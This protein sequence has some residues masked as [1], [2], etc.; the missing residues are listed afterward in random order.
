M[1][2]KYAIKQD[3]GNPDNWGIVWE[4][5]GTQGGFASE[6]AAR[7]NADK[8]GGEPA[9]SDEAQVWGW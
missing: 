7:A 2:E 8:Q 3:P 6:D 4:W 1:T 9:S 5:S